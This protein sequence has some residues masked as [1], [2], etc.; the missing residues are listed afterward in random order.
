[1]ARSVYQKFGKRFFDWVL[2]LLLL[3][4]LWPIFLIIGLLVKLDSPGPAIFRQRRVGQNGKIFT[5]YKF[6]TMIVGAEKLQRKYRHLNEADGSV[7]KIHNDP[8]FTRIGRFLSHTGLD[9][10]PQLVNVLK[11]EMSL[12][13][14][15]PLPVAEER[16]LPSATRQLRASV[17][18]GLVSSWLVQGA[19]RLSFATWLKLDAE[20][21]HEPS[22][23]RD[24]RILLGALFMALQA[25]KYKIQDYQV[26]RPRSFRR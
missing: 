11:G 22:F 16:R 10:L 1:M 26:K 20:D 12:V 8:R 5:I 9:E 21:I 25:V 4:F 2:A 14:P 6:R 17:R 18:P 13:G 19:H 7:F 3:I 23:S 15:R 24:L